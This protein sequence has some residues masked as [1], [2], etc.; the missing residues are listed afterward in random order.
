M[1]LQNQRSIDPYDAPLAKAPAFGLLDLRSRAV[2]GGE[3]LVAGGKED[4]KPNPPIHEDQGEQVPESK[5]R[6][7]KQHACRNQ[8]QAAAAKTGSQHLYFLRIRCILRKAD[9]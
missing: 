6:Q 4:N 9:A 1:L 2:T 5:H 8:R 7:Q 3:Q